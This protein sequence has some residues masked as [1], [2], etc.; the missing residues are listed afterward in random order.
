MVVVKGQSLEVLVD[1]YFFT[2]LI[3]YTE[4]LER[5]TTVE[6]VFSE[7]KVGGEIVVFIHGCQVPKLRSLETCG[8]ILKFDT[9]VSKNRGTPKW[10]VY[11][12]KPY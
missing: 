5:S 4:L 6:R 3:D 10:M 11:N 8:E 1:Y 9:G 12:G 7:A 2:V